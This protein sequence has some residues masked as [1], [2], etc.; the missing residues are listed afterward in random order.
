MKNF[1]TVVL[2]FGSSILDGVES[3]PRAVQTIQSH[4]RK[5]HRVV[6]V[7]SALAGETDQ[8]LDAVNQLDQEAGPH[9]IASFVGLGEKKSALLLTI[10]LERVGLVTRQI[11]PEDIALT[12]VGDPLDSDPKS[13]D[14]QTFQQLLNTCQVAVLPGFIA[15]DYH[16]RTVLLGR[17]GSD[18]SALFIAQ[19][20]NAGCQLVKDVNGIYERDP[21]GLGP[22]PRRFSHISWP[23]ALKVAGELVQPKAIRFAEQH[24]MS[25]EV[26]AIGSNS[27]TV[28]GPGPTKLE[29]IDTR[30]LERI[31]LCA[32]FEQILSVQ[33]R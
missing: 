29:A 5:G 15:N 14:I 22:V 10:A 23:D 11:N 31:R 12:A 13:V 32:P 30:D 21:N 6:A 26:A 24:H 18:D 25:F 4:V 7:V 9:R 28:V 2:K 16:G 1:S 20:L 8:L 3:V 17:G 19:Q 33:T 27:G